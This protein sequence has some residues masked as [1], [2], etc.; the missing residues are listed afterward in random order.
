MAT[1][2]DHEIVCR[3]RAEHE[4]RDRAFAANKHSTRR[5]SLIKRANKLTK[6]KS[7]KISVSSGGECVHQAPVNAEG[8]G[9]SG[10]NR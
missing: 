6:L 5:W 1:L 9:L 4:Y 2:D 10:R 3:R 7:E 8:L